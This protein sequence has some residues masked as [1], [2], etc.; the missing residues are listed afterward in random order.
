MCSDGSK[1]HPWLQIYT[2]ISSVLLETVQTE[3]VIAAFLVYCYLSP[4]P[5][6]GHPY[7]RSPQPQQ[8]E[9]TSIGDPPKQK[10]A[11]C[12]RFPRS[13][14]FWSAFHFLVFVNEHVLPRCTSSGFFSNL[15][16]NSWHYTFTPFITETFE[17][18][19]NIPLSLVQSLR[20][21]LELH[22][23]LQC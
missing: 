12:P 9:K 23:L 19:T 16:F 17:K 22:L 18:I 21:N 8:L 20:N 7:L 13:Q 10:R 5:S 6:S 14:H 11:L 1:S 2:K 4:H 15:F 3:H